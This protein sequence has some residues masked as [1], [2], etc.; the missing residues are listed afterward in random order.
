MRGDQVRAARSAIRSTAV[1]GIALLAALVGGVTFY[2]RRLERHARTRVAE[3]LAPSAARLSSTIQQRFAL[4]DGVRSWIEF[5]FQV[6]RPLEVRDLDAFASSIQASALG[7]RAIQTVRDGIIDYT[8]PVT[9]NE[10]ALGLDLAHDRRPR[11]RQEYQRARG[12]RSIALSG[13]FELAQGGLGLVARRTVWK[14]GRQWGLVAMVL[15]VP[16]VLANAHLPTA[17]G[18][19][20][21]A[22]RDGIGQ[23]FHGDPGV[24]DRQPVL[25]GIELPD[26]AWQLAGA[27]ALARGGW[28]ALVRGPLLR[29][30]LG[31]LLA[32]ALLSSVVWVGLARREQQRW[33]EG[34][35]ARRE[36]EGWRRAVRVI[37]HEIGNSLA[38]ISSL[39]DSARVAAGRPDK[40]HLV[41]K[42][43]ATIGE[44]AA[45]L[46][47]FL[48]SY[49]Q[50]ARAPRP[51]K[52][53]TA[54]GPFLEGLRA[55]YPFRGPDLAPGRGCCFD[56]GQME[57]VLINLLK[58]AHEAGG[59]P[60]EVEVTLVE[61]AGS[62]TVLL[63][64]RDRGLGMNAETT[65]RA[66][67][68]FFTTKAGGSGIGLFL[69]RAIVE[70]HG[71]TME[72]RARAG[73]GTEVMVTLPGE[74]ESG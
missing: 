10:K 30:S 22:L 52:V 37:S 2:Q 59:P 49:A 14:Q 53:L 13:P 21:I 39:V 41:Q 51:N 11:V 63:T 4:L 8:Y 56:P 34:E 5:S 33:F 16:Q 73:G 20:D 72:I 18:G 64:V 7:V 42:S 29:F 70:A 48:T 66:A 46:G 28:P 32:I 26:G 6:A 23:V 67:E 58:N 3:Q 55:M 19:L 47:A 24:F 50:L 65:A 62:D 9:G 44:R 54:W 74:D 31:G 27:P 1:V 35:A 17:T 60:G 71:G 12:M 15:D 68:P 43:L 57:Q 38:P 61:P 25:V 69:C 40:E 36:L 45:H